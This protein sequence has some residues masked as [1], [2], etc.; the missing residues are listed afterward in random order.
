MD[1]T[2]TKTFT[3]RK[4]CGE[5]QTI[6]SRAFVIK[7]ALYFALIAMII[8]LSFASDTFLKPSNIINVLRQIS[9][10]AIIAVGMTMVIIL[11]QMDLSVGAI[12]AFASVV[13]ALLVMKAGIPVVLAILIT[14]FLSSLWGLLNG[15]VTAKFKLHAFLV[16]LAT[17]TLIRGITYTLTGGYP[18]GGL[19]KSF[20][21]FGS[22]H[23]FKIPY[24]VLYMVVIYAIGMFVLRN[25]PFGR[26]IYSVGGN[27]E[28]ARLSG[29][30]IF[31]TK[32]AVF[33]I[34]SFLAAIGGIILSS[35]LRAGSPEVGL[36]WELDIVAAVIIGGTNI[37]G[38]EGKLTGTLIGMLFVGILTNGM[39]LLD[40]T[41]YMQQV[42]RGIVILA[43]VIL[44]SLQEK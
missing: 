29:I 15:L 8:I 7:Y 42:V 43:A 6:F 26:S 5:S 32:V 34:S 44:N 33:V 30:N 28:A 4:P 1:M 18:I 10:Q 14:L 35:R 39:I 36:G 41:P 20:Y 37:F 40:V 19:P 17:L 2:A 38:G 13:N 16:T 12:V 25:T 27:A 21:E 22:G 31:R 24:P 9:I 23:L 11:G 3:N